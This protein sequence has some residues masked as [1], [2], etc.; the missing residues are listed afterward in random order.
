[1]K[2]QLNPANFS[3]DEPPRQSR[4][5]HIGQ[6]LNKHLPSSSPQGEKTI[7]ALQQIG[8]VVAIGAALVGG[9]STSCEFADGGWLQGV[10]LFPVVTGA[11]LVVLT[12]IGGI[13]FGGRVFDY[14]LGY[15]AFTLLVFGILWWLT[16]SVKM[17]AF[18]ADAALLA[19]ICFMYRRAAKKA[20]NESVTPL[21]TEKENL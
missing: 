3:P 11:I 10:L 17:A 21:N 13:A 7:S 16:T 20:K 1:M 2:S 12:L 14:F 15:G 19:F 18:C 5:Q 6:Q 9:F 4:W 8:G